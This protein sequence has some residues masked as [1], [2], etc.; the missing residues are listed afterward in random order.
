MLTIH[1]IQPAIRE[2]RAHDGDS[3]SLYKVKNFLEGVQRV[4][5]ESDLTLDQ[6]ERLIHDIDTQRVL[7]ID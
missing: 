3:V 2:P 1:R 7:C 6:K 5:E 4:L